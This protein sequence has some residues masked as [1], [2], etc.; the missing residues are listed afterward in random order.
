MENQMMNGTEM[1][2]QEK[3]RNLIEVIVV[4]AVALVLLLIVSYGSAGLAQKDILL[5]ANVLMLVTEAL[6]PLIGIGYL[7]VKKY[8]L[9][10]NLGLHKIRVTTALWSVLLGLLVIPVTS[11][12]NVLTQFLV[13]NTL[14]QASDSLI[15]N[16]AGSTLFIGAVAAPICEELL[17]RG[18]IFHRL[19]ISMKTIFAIILSALLFG[20][21]H[22]NFNQLCYAAVLGLFFA[23]VDDICDSIYP[24]MI[25]HVVVNGLNLLLLVV[26]SAAMEMTGQDLGTAAE[27][28]RNSAQFG[29]TAIVYGI[30]SII[31][32]LLMLP[33]FRH[34][35]KI[36]AQENAQKTEEVLTQEEEQSQES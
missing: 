15:G 24:S 1:T 36:R 31:C 12:V 27:E 20:I 35:R 4:F 25:M 26:V 29:Q 9:I 3:T 5:N 23:Y 17:F 28:A 33:I 6:M 14:V 16:G 30:L 10:E 8:D 18:M 32:I 21:M 13:P 11:F 7:L 34:L 2:K 22:M 19:K